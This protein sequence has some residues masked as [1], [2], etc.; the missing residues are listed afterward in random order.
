MRGSHVSECPL[1]QALQSTL[2][3]LT[4]VRPGDSTT[5][6]AMGATV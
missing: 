5:T 2:A 6:G 4:E 1:S 3:V